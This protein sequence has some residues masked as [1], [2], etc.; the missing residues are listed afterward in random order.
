L[1]LDAESSDADGVGLLESKVTRGGIWI[2]TLVYRF[3]PT[4]ESG[5][6]RQGDLVQFT[7]H[8]KD[9]GPWAA[10]VVP[11]EPP[12]QCGE[13]VETAP[14]SSAAAVATGASQRHERW[15]ARKTSSG[16]L[17]SYDRTP[18]GLC[19]PESFGSSDLKTR[20]CSQSWAA[21][22]RRMSGS[23]S[24][25]CDGL[26][27]IQAR[28]QEVVGSPARD[29]SPPACSS[30]SGSRSNRRKSRKRTMDTEMPG[31]LLEAT[32]DYNVDACMEL[33]SKHA[34]AKGSCRKAAAL[35]HRA[36][37]QW[38]DEESLVN[39]VA[40][41]G[42][43]KVR[44]MDALGVGDQRELRAVL[45]R[46]V[47]A[48]AVPRGALAM[49]SESGLPLDEAAQE[50]LQQ[51]LQSRLRNLALRCLRGLDLEDP[52]SAPA[53][54]RL[55]ELILSFECQK[56]T[57]VSTARGGRQ[58]Q[59]LKRF[60]ESC[61]QVS[62]VVQSVTTLPR[63]SFG[64]TLEQSLHGLQSASSRK[65]NYTLVKNVTSALGRRG[66]GMCEHGRTRQHCSL[67]KGCPHGRLKQNCASC[68]GCAHGKLKWVCKVCSR[69]PHGKAKWSCVK[70][71]GCPHGRKKT[72]CA[73]CSSCIHGKVKH[74][75]G[76]CKGC[77]H[78]RLKRNCPKCNG[79]EH[80][81]LRAHCVQCRGCPHGHLKRSCSQCSGCPH[82]KLRRNCP[83]CSGCPHGKLRVVCG[84]C[85]GC[86]HGNAKSLCVQC[87]GCP[88][89]KMVKQCVECSGCQHGRLKR[90]CRQCT[91][92]PHG[93]VKHHCAVCTG[94]PHGK[95]K[96][97]CLTCSGCPHGR[98]KRNCSDCT[99]C[100]HGKVRSKCRLCKT[101][102]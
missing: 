6:V 26:R 97:S 77:P 101:L 7:P 33:G 42:H 92:C 17:H 55:Q 32:I 20:R 2:G 24:C 64:P 95:L 78:G 27:C 86:P 1:L 37:Q 68:R 56:S 30:G 63:P 57:D 102:A 12:G 73:H 52:R 70:C 89:G 19:Q 71:V 38:K 96:A 88:H 18:S 9:S 14:A 41:V 23:G 34:S 93:K 22:K 98:L 79:C 80:G 75:C 85:N 40:Y 53:L 82:G 74:H 69:C 43:L 83:Q 10:D 39:Q 31:E 76:I 47:A 8:M 50:R 62:S 58:W 44:L 67:C 28:S 13:V 5:G 25:T 15:T 59:Q 45:R 51:A 66:S 91:G 48:L 87:V 3:E 29:P 60:S 4:R 99:G 84:Q 49:S 81:R 11:L 21:G 94:C 36:E 61:S 35:L 72:S 90:N 46:I 65:D 54:L 100:T 16:V